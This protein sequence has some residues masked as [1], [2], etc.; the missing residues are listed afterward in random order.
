MK[1][2]NVKAII[3][4]NESIVSMYREFNNRVFTPFRDAV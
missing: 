2:I 4:V 1:R 3:M